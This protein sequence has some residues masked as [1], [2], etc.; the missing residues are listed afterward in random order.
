[1]FFYNSESDIKEFDKESQI[2]RFRRNA[3]SLI[4][5]V[6][7]YAERKSHKPVSPNVN[8]GFLTSRIPGKMFSSKLFIDIIYSTYIYL[9]MSNQ[10]IFISRS[11]TRT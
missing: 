10:F 9:F 7:D 5:Y 8:F 11:S 1:M 6:C 3:T 4:E 2:K